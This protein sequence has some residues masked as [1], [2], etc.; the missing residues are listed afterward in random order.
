MLKLKLLDDN[1]GVISWLFTQIGLML[2]AGVLIG[3]IASL[4]FYSDWQKEAEAK[5]IASNFAAAVESVCLKE[6][7]GNITYLFPQKSYNYEVEI[8]TDYITVA[9]GGG[10]TT[11]KIASREKLIIKPYVRP[12]GRGWNWNN[13]E[14]LHAFL[15]NEYGHSGYVDDVFP[16]YQKDPVIS[17]LR[18]E[19]SITAA[20]LASNPLCVTN[21]DE[22]IFVEKTFVY[23]KGNGGSLER[24]GIVIIHQEVG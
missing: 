11:D 12:A 19:L 9:R 6:F 3:S 23:F 14:E 2:A 18:G 22:P 1:R 13:S 20:K 16:K 8:S 7:P 24:E 21:T 10:T 15:K 17:Y 5:N 4:T